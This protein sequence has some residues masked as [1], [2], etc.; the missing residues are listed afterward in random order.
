M[1]NDFLSLLLHYYYQ[2]QADAFQ[3]LRMYKLSLFDHAPI[4]ATLYL[5]GPF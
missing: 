1:H 2:Q 5:L 3:E 4:N